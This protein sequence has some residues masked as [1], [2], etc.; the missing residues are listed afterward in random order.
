MT[1]NCQQDLPSQGKLLEGALWDLTRMMTFE[2]EAGRLRL[3]GR[4]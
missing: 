2:A 4:R 3:E 1:S